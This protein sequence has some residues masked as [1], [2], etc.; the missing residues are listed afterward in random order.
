MMMMLMMMSAVRFEAPLTVCARCFGSVVAVDDD[1]LCLGYDDDLCL[2]CDDLCFWY[3]DVAPYLDYADVDGVDVLLR[4]PIRNYLLSFLHYYHCCCY[5]DA[6]AY[7]DVSSYSSTSWP[8]L[9][10]CIFAFFERP[11]PSPVTAA[12]FVANVSA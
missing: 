9:V 10:S 6:F 1:H 4:S 7:F 8:C 11:C 2:W 3:D 12:T 5:C